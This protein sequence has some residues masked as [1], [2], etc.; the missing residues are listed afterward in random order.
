MDH[1]QA[2]ENIH[3]KIIQQITTNM[4]SYGYPG[5]IGHVIAVV[6]YHNAPMSLDELAQ[7]TGMS[8]TRMSQVLREM[9]QLNIAEKVFVKGSRKDYYTIESDYYKTFISLF[10]SNWRE[11]YIRNKKIEQDLIEDLDGI[12][13]D[14]DASE[15]EINEAKMYLDDTQESL[16]FFNWIED[17][18]DFFESGEIF[19]HVPKRKE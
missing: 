6:Y 19:K 5:T 2:L 11:V 15:E 16:E 3:H 7:E 14:S 9:V 18:V 8:K 10:T 17:L 1:K 4:K 12:V 13:N